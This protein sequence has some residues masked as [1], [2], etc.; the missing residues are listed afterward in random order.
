MSNDIHDPTTDTIITTQ[1]K[2]VQS[3][4]HLLRVWL[5]RADCVTKLNGSI[6]ANVRT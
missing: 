2:D 5:W 6:E 3:R 4:E 1:Q